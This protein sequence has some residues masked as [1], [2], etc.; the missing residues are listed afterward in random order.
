VALP[1]NTI[2]PGPIKIGA[3]HFRHVV[4]RVESIVP[5]AGNGIIIKQLERGVEI[6]VDPE[7]VVN[8]AQAGN[9]ASCASVLELNIC[10]NGVPDSIYVLG[11]TD[12]NQV[13]ECNYG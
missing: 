5:R 4:E 2:P 9:I 3:E 13:I 6:S 7:Q 12:E 8:P 11:F 10:K 1:L